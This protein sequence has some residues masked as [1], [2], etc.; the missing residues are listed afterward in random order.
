MSPTLELDIAVRSMPLPLDE[1]PYRMRFAAMVSELRNHPEI[2]IDDLELGEPLPKDQ[3][4]YLTE[5]WH[6]TDAMRDFYSQLNGFKLKWTYRANPDV[7]GS[8]YLLPLADVL[9]SWEEQIWTSDTHYDGSRDKQ[10]HALD[11]FHE[12]ICCAEYFAEDGSPKIFWVGDEQVDLQLS[13]AAYLELLL[14]SRG[15][16]FWQSAIKSDLTGAEYTV[17]PQVFRGTMP[18]LFPDY[19]PA[20]FLRSAQAARHRFEALEGVE[21]EAAA[22]RSFVASVPSL[23]PSYMKFMEDGDSGA[24]VPLLMDEDYEVTPFKEAW[25]L[26]HALCAHAGSSPRPDYVEFAISKVGQHSQGFPST[27]E[28]IEALALPRLFERF[29]LQQLQ[30]IG[31]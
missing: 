27:P 29:S 22:I 11:Y 8:I 15:F 16:R 7:G 3:F 24:A 12:T 4:E 20:H 31:I 13:F 21:G 23:I 19:D 17:E 10:V 2:E 6:L 25:I 30:D 9:S 1:R 28:G 14:M 5:E 26:H 18:I